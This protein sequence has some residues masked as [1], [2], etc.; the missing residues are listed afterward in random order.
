[1]L[2]AG[3]SSLALGVAEWCGSERGILRIM[4]ARSLKQRCLL[5]Q[6]VLLQRLPSQGLLAREPLAPR[7]GWRACWA[8]RSTCLGPGLASGVLAAGADALLPF[9]RL[10]AAAVPAAAGRLPAAIRWP[11]SPAAGMPRSWHL[12]C[13][14]LRSGAGRQPSDRPVSG[15]AQPVYVQQP[16]QAKQNRGC[17]EAWCVRCRPPAL[18]SARKCVPLH[19]S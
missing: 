7:K 17:L 5:K 13:C 15:C 16:Q 9:S 4:R 10:P 6:A 8:G 2:G 19:M 1:M 14:N 18:L 3:A 11:A 12:L